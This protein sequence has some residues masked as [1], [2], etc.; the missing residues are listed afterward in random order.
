MSRSFKAILL[1]GLL[2]VAGMAMAQGVTQKDYTTADIAAFHGDANSL[3][4]A[5]QS[6]EQS[7]SGKVLEI[8]F[9]DSGGQPGYHA[10]VLKGNDVE[11][12]RL[13]AQSGKLNPMD[14]KSRPVWMLN[15]RTKDYIK[16]AQNARVDL[17]QAIATAEKGYDNMPAVAAGIAM[18]ASTSEVHAYNVLLDE[19]TGTKR[20]AVDANDDQIIADPQALSGWPS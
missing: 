15:M 20:V 7:S 2:P 16:D 17:S 1:A 9:T 8:R 13:D 4:Q 18:T 19:R 3:A 11:F 5:I 12:V 14:E 6:I 10:A